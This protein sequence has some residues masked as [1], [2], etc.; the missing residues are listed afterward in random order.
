MLVYFRTYNNLS[1]SGEVEFSMVAGNYTELPENTIVLP[2]KNKVSIL[3]S[4]VVFGA[5]ASGKSNLLRAISDGAMM[6]VQSTKDIQIGDKL[7]YYPFKNRLDKI[8]EPTYYHFGII[9]EGSHFDYYFKFNEDIILEESLT[10]YATQKPIHHFHR[11]YN[12]ETTKYDWTFSEKYFKGEKEKMTEITNPSSLYLSVSAQFNL[13]VSEKVFKW[14]KTNFAFSINQN[15][16]GGISLNFTLKLI[17]E[18]EEMKKFILEGLSIADFMIKDIVVSDEVDMR[19]RINATTFHEGIGV[20]GNPTLIA[21]DL[22]DE[23]STGTQRFLAWLG[24]FL[25]VLKN[26][27]VLIIDELGNSMHTLLLRHLVSMF[28]NP[29]SNPHNAQ[30]IFT[31]HDTNVMDL[32]LMRRDQIWIVDRDEAGCS[33]LFPISDF[34]IKKGKVLENSYLQGVY[35]GIPHIIN[36]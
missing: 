18:N 14:F 7:P 8:S 4:S 17:K 29:L 28:H 22:F 25:D 35:G 3:K 11:V 12:Y 36:Q 5:N 27:K 13:P 6:I 30:L 1:Y 19:K 2:G 31:T 16:P 9:V 26:G 34:K 15:S 10:E 20:D 32:N 24:I 23:E 33:S 21:F